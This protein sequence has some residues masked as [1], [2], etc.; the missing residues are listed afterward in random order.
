M[1]PVRDAVTAVLIHNG[2]VFLCRRQPHL[3]AF[4]G[5]YAFPGGKVDTTDS[6]QPTGQPLLDAHPAKAMH[7]LARELMEETGFDLPQACASG[8]VKSVDCLGEITTP[9]FVPTRFRTWFF[10]IVLNARPT[11]HM[12]SDEAMDSV[13]EP[14]RALCQRYDR[15]QL[16]AAPPTLAALDALANAPD[17]TRVDLARMRHEYEP[18]SQVPSV[19]PLR[20]LRMLMVR[21]NTLPPAHHTNA[22]L[23]GD[24]HKVL[25]DPSPCSREELEKL[26]RTLQPLGVHEVFLTHHHPDHREYADE[27]ARHFRVPLG[28]SADTRARITQKS[29]DKFFGDL[30]IKIYRE[31]DELTR[32]LGEAVQIIE[33]PGHD[34]GQLALMPV[35]R[36]WCIVGDLI[37]GIGTVVISP[38]EGNMRKYF[39]SMK[40]II[41]LDPQVVIPS[42]GAALGT[43]YRI[44]EALKHREARETQIF[45]LH[46]AGRDEDQILDEVYKGTP[47]VLLPLARINIRSHMTKLREEGRLPA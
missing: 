7:A 13:W 2:D 46:S 20:G 26:C 17:C 10:K 23:F 30:E 33:V 25:V 36:S 15:G 28:M 39:D 6:D 44:R 31:G 19:E 42:H 40:K 5:Y 18:D 29:G 43:T 11:L 38:P 9:A 4:G 34:E 21:S 32:W 24:V 45:S 22:F 47:P 16:L 35:S 41:A 37:Q 12:N 8:E 3:P 27:V 14:A 1:T